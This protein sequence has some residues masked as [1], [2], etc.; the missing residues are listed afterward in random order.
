MV[1][2]KEYVNMSELYKKIKESIVPTEWTAI[3]TSS[4][5]NNITYTHTVEIHETY[6]L[7]ELVV[8]LYSLKILLA[9]LL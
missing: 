8:G 6:I 7:S 4:K 9:L 5:E 2:G 3:S 1:L